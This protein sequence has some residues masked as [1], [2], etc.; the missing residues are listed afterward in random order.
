MD[1]QL[2]KEFNE[3]TIALYNEIHKETGYNATRFLQMISSSSGYEA[4]KVLI[5]ANRVSEELTKLWEF[6]RL[7]LSIEAE[8][9]KEKWSPIF[10]C[11]EKAIAEKCLLELGYFPRNY[12]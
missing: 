7:D 8:I 11:D 3:R 9:L 10:T 12:K 2:I 6:K 1:N 4:T 5:R